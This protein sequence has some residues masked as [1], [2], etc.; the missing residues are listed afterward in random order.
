MGSSNPIKSA[1][2]AVSKA[3][4]QTESAVST[5]YK[6][7]ENAVSAVQHWDSN[8]W[9]TAAGVA[10]AA[11][12]G[13]GLA[14]GGLTTGAAVSTTGGLSL[15]AAG[16]TG[17]AQENAAEEAKAAEYQAQAEARALQDRLDQ[18]DYLMRLQAGIDTKMSKTA[19]TTYGS[20]SANMTTKD[21]LIPITTDTTKK[22]QLIGLGF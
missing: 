12:G 21:L 1:T 17:K 18:E 6:Q 20:T 9:M 10:L 2:K 15:A 13:Y 11:Y 4:K 14:T 3:V 8:D 16:Q 7:T 5:A 19:K 22:P